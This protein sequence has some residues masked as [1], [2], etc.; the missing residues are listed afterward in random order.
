VYNVR[1]TSGPDHHRALFAGC[2]ALLMA[3]ACTA[4]D[5]SGHASGMLFIRDCVKMGGELV[6]FPP[7][8]AK[9]Q[10]F[11]LEPQFFAAEP[12]E[13]ISQGR[14][15]N[16]LLIRMQRSGKR[17]ELNDTVMFDVISSYELA[18]C[19]RGR[20]KADGT[21]DFDQRSCFQTPDG[22]RVRV[23]PDSYLRAYLLPRSTCNRT[24]QGISVATVQGVAVSPD[25]WTGTVA[26]IDGGVSEGDA[27]ASEADAGALP[28][29]N[30]NGNFASYAEFAAFG[31]A[32][33]P[34]NVPAQQRPPVSENFRVD[35]SQRIH[36]KRFRLTLEDQ[37]VNDARKREEPLP[38][39]N[40]HGT[41]EGFFDFELERGQG[42]QSFP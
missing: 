30:V 42:A 35:F 8:N 17:F 25:D 18:R 21:P 29:G 14:K 3:T 38:E 39:S 1:V 23:A 5:G 9:K 37:R 33:L 22:P 27:G 36:A 13:D 31:S 40:L 7:P 28:G 34:G 26:K 20:I 16:R 6:D 12:I 24:V 32:V 2:A 4:G 41:L 19:L 15:S 10:I 11:D